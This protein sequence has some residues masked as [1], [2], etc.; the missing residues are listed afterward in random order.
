MKFLKPGQNTY[1][2]VDREFLD[3]TNIEEVAR[4]VEEKDIKIIIN[5]AA[6]TNVDACEGDGANRAFHVNAFG[7]MKLG[8]V[9]AKRGGMVIH[10]STDYVYTPYN[11]WKGEPFEVW[12]MDS[13]TDKEKRPMNMY[14][15]TKYLGET[16]LIESGCEYVIIRTSWLYSTY[17]KNF[18]NTM[19]EKLAKENTLNVVNDQIGT[20]T[21][22]PGLAAFIIDEICQKYEKLTPSQKHSIVNYSDEGACSWYDFAKEIQSLTGGLRPFEPTV[23]P[24]ATNMY[25]RPA[26]RPRYSVMDHGILRHLFPDVK[27]DWWKDNLKKCV[28]DYYNE[29]R[30]H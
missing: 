1:D 4:Y 21:W 27:L 6:Y 17:G 30:K 14:G 20:P 8:E 3:I 5:C 7:P 26:V 9:M 19:I 2:F 12:K 29:Q 23:H 18:F 15:L 13:E 22:A 25:P 11:G 10:I 24:C 16:A 28:N